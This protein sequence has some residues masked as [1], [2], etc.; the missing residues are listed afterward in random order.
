MPSAIDA[1]RHSFP[2][3]LPLATGLLLAAAVQAYELIGY[4]WPDGPIPIHLQL[5]TTPAPLLDGA[6]DWADVAEAALADWNRQQS[7]VAFAP[8]RNASSPVA[9]GDGLNH[10]AFRPDLFGMYLD[11][12]VL[13]ITV[14]FVSPSSGRAIE[15][16]VIFNAKV[17]WNSY[18][19]P[20]RSPVQ[21]FRRL[22]LHELGHVLGL[23]HPDQASPSQVVDAIMNSSPTGVDG[24]KLDDIAG[25]RALYQVAPT[26]GPPVLIAEP[27]S[28]FLLQG[29]TFTVGATIGG[30]S[31][32]VCSWTFQAA[33]ASSPEPFPLATG[34]S[35][36]IGS[37]YPTDAGNYTLTVR[38]PFGSVTARPATLRVFEISPSTETALANI[39]TRG[40][41]G[42]GSDVLIAGLV[43]SGT[44]PK[45]V[46]IR[47]AG[48]ALGAFGVNGA[49]A[50]PTLALVNQAGV[51]LA[52][53]DNW[54]DEGRG[55]QI[56]ST[57]SAV[58]A[59]QFRPGSRDAALVA[60]L[61]PGSYTAVVSG[62]AAATGVALVEV[63]ETDAVR[64]PGN[65]QRLVNI[66]TR[67]RVGTGE[68]NLIAG[69]V[70]SGPGPRTYLIRGV[71]PSLAGVPFN[72]SDPLP[73]PFLQV[74]RGETLLRENDDWDTPR[75]TQPS[76]G[77]AASR[78]GAFP[79]QS[80]RDAALLITLPPG[81]YT[82]RLSGVGG[83]S[84]VGLV[85]V[86]ELR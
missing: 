73:N 32:L 41:V 42:A 39:S 36:T 15:H 3:T 7:G 46:L 22:A 57:C 26:E 12:R 18:R 45:S 85:E 40:V 27:H 79:L 34:P 67:G 1:M 13:A 75:S 70:V 77:S 5:G 50:D 65:T 30:A 48:P 16:D 54:E 2:H 63:Y 72:V 74:F 81:G 35:Y 68:N 61:A 84:G 78:V 20:L 59:F 56:T 60:T 43:I 9:S 10:L 23:D 17:S 64:T 44:T 80:G 33:D 38:N 28:R 62:A 82:A 37:L 8:I 31:P 76:L 53:N 47:A 21:D 11:A 69:L 51:T 24:L 4:R 55:P 49:L 66:A 71:G 19:G 14:G 58:G 83:T 86:Y 52:R 6:T 29:D 25:V